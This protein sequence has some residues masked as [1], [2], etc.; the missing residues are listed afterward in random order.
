VDGLDHGFVLVRAGHGQNIGEPRADRLGLV[1]HAPGHDHAAIFGNRL[2]DRGQAFLLGRIEE[3][4]GVDQN[5][6]GPGI[7]GAHRIAIGAQAGE[8]AFGIDERLG[9]AEADQSDALGLGGGGGVDFA[10]IRGNG[11]HCGRAH[12]RKSAV[13]HYVT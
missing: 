5:D 9:T 6:I 1:A 11:G 2:A 4:A 13:R 3:A 7:V 12:T 8:D 10:G